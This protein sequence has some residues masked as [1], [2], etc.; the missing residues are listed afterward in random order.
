VDGHDIPLSGGD[1]DRWTAGLDDEAAARALV[2]AGVDPAGLARWRS[3]PLPPAQHVAGAPAPF[4]V[5][6]ASRRTPLQGAVADE[7]PVTDGFDPESSYRLARALRLE[8]HGDLLPLDVA[9]RLLNCAGVA[10]VLL[11]VARPPGAL[12]RRPWSWPLRIGLLDSTTSRSPGMLGPDLGE[13]RDVTVDPGPVDVLFVAAPFAEA[14]ARVRTLRPLANAVVCLG[15]VGGAW[16]LVDADLAQLRASTS[17]IVTVVPTGRRVPRAELVLAMLVRTLSLGHPF[18]VAVTAAMDRRALVVGEP[19][20]LAA[21]TVQQVIGLTAARMR[22]DVGALQSPMSPSDVL[23]LP[24]AEFDTA[25]DHLEALSTGGFDQDGE[26]TK[27]GAVVTAL[28]ETLSAALSTDEDARPRLLQVYVGRPGGPAAEPGNVLS[29][30]ANVVDVF[31]G[32]VEEHALAGARVTD[33]QLGFD[34]PTVVSARVTVQLVPLMPPG[35]PVRAEMDVPRVGRSTTASLPLVVPAGRR[36]VQ[37]RLIVSHRNRVLQTAVLGGTVGSPAR[38]RE[39]LVL[40]RDLAHLDD[41]SGFDHAIVLNHADNGARSVIGLKDGEV[42]VEAMAEVD[43][44]TGHLRDLLIAASAVT[45]TGKAAREKLRVAFVDLAEWGN[46]LF[47]SLESSLVR[48]VTAQRIQ[49]VSARPGRFLPLELVYDR[50]TPD[51]DA[52]LCARWTAGG[53][54]CG[55]GCFSGPDDTTVVCPSVFWGLSRVIE[56]HHASLTDPSGFGF[57]LS[58]KARTRTPL[59][60]RTA[61]VA[62]SSKVSDADMATVLDGLGDSATGVETWDAWK[63]ALVSAARDL[64]VLMPH[65]DPQ[66][67]TMEISSTLLALSRVERF[68]VTGGNTASPIVVLFGC[69]TGGSEEDPAGYAG[70]FMS[71]NAAVVFST[72]TMLL[73]RHAAALSHELTSML[74]DPD[75]DREP[76]GALTTRFRRECVQQGL[77]PALAVTAYGDADWTV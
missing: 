6:A 63:S 51:E 59:T 71:K 14:V 3:A 30:G 18:D 68:Y 23:T 17:A 29:E 50:P 16:A 70:R 32:P 64:L 15:P 9:G 25:V 61:L 34:D 19:D 52:R 53:K 57:E 11:P 62:A 35:V 47:N 67:K 76:L 38:L 69:D 39:G 43:E 20:A 13:V 72:L 2:T 56:R 75:R 36:R 60:V 41:R 27:A 4:V 37:A 73:N 1:L 7:G 45:G 66:S 10:S 22:A 26:A 77:L 58:A 44:A 48:L 55:P 46:T 8:L 33:Q 65:T 5:W 74:R 40:H 12:R 31:I 24:D 42:W 28:D 21:V 49:I 54:G